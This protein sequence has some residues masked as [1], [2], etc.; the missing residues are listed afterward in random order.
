MRPDDHR[1]MSRLT[2]GLIGGFV[3]SLTIW[4]YECVVFYGA[5][6]SS[7]LPGI[8]QHTALLV[9]GP[10]ILERPLAAFV[11]GAVIHCLTG[12]VWGVVFAS[13]WPALRR[14][15]VEVTLAA[16]GFGIVA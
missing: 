3:G 6:H 16:L 2:A 10:G 4:V 12:I 11:W 8:V 13:L 9:F 7:S 15:G 5:M 1:P 14:T